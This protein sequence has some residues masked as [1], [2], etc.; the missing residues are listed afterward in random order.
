MNPFIRAFSSRFALSLFFLILVVCL[1][2][3]NLATSTG[4][5]A[6]SPTGASMSEPQRV[7]LEKRDR[8]NKLFAH[9]AT[10]NAPG[11]V[12]LV[13]ENGEIAYEA[14]Y[15]LSDLEKRIPLTTKDL[16]HLGSVGKQFTALGI[17]MLVEQGR[18]KLD[19][20]IGKSLPELTRFGPRLTIRHLLNHTSGIPDYYGDE[21]LHRRILSRSAMPTNDDALKVLSRFGKP[22]FL[23]GEKSEYSNTGYDILGSVIERASGLPYAEFMA[24]R[25]FR[26]LGMKDT[27]SLPSSRRAKDSH[28]AHS[29]VR[30]GGK[31][32][33][34]DSDPFDNLVGSG[35]FYTTVGDMYLYDQALYTDKLIP[36]SRLA[37]A[38]Q[39]TT[40]NDGREE[41]YGFGWELGTHFR[42]R[43]TAHNG[44][45]LGF[46]SAYVRFPDQHL[47]VIVLLNR[48]YGVDA[49]KLAFD[50]S[51]VYLR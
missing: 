16:F 46:T 36:Q 3:G 26:P 40:L 12:V 42:K 8:V 20:P 34:Y 39:P 51:D 27:F 1:F 44:A 21:E 5:N 49:Q 31:I 45:W 2:P 41:L 48:D 50:V 24:R 6:V 38:F 17:L 22:H 33:A 15:G 35:S 19:D 18:L 32:K 10:H 23:A 28:I 7:S 29:Y 25:V 47:S 37:D 43:F 13:I 9:L 14:A 4:A 30:D 11:G